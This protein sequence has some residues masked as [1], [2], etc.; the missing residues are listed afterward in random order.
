MKN[1][2]LAIAF[3]FLCFAPAAGVFVPAAALG[4]SQDEQNSCINDAFNICGQ[5]GQ[6]GGLP[7]AQSEAHLAGLPHR[8]AALPEAF[9]F[10]GQIFGRRVAVPAFRPNGQ[11]NGI[12]R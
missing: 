9:G 4:E 8:D 6:G 1:T 2:Q 5:D 11:E 12:L 10:A 3:A 7:G